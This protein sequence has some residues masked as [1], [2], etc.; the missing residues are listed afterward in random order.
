MHAVLFSQ[1]KNSHFLMLP[2]PLEMSCKKSGGPGNEEDDDP[3]F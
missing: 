3:K 2:G 1:L